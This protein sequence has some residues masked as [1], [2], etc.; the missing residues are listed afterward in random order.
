MF[1]TKKLMFV[2]ADMGF[3]FI[4]GGVACQHAFI[5][6]GVTVVSGAWFARRSSMFRRLNASDSASSK[7]TCR[8]ITRN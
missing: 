5:V 3:F 6:G 1:E 4:L 2:S 8:T 7:R